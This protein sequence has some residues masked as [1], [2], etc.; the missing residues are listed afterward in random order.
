MDSEHIVR[1]SVYNV[2]QGAKIAIETLFCK[3]A[4]IE[5]ISTY[6]KDIARLTLGEDYLFFEAT[7]DNVS[8]QTV[9]WTISYCSEEEI[10][11][12]TGCAGESVFTTANMPAFLKDIVASH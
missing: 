10:I 6:Q 5:N 12:K 11:I 9:H 4:R 7:R 2:F 1:E 8:K 3:Q